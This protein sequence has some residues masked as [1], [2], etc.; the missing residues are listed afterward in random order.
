MSAYLLELHCHTSNHS[1]DGFVPAADVVRRLLELQFSGVVFTDHN[2]CWPAEELAELRRESGA[3][4]DFVMLSGQ[5]VSTG[6]NGVTYGDLLVYGIAEPLDDGM[7]PIALFQLLRDR[8]GFAIAPH[9]A[10]SFNGFGKHVG[11]FPVTAVE[12]WNARYGQKIAAGSRQIAETYGRPGVG[13]SDSHRIEEV[14]RGGTMFPELPR[15]LVR[16]QH[17]IASGQAQPWGEPK[18]LRGMLDRFFGSAEAAD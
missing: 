10:A 9:A 15:D 8:G 16:L 4:D 17:L 7:S 3:P 6:L 5:E 12:V 14:G 18:G 1:P 13:G 2:Y 11:S